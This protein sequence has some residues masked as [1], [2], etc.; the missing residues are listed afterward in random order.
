[1]SL[2][3]AG[4][5]VRAADLTSIFPV[6]VD[7]WQPYIP[8]WTASGSNPSIGNGSINGQYTKIGRTVLFRASITAG[9]TTTFGSGNYSISLPVAGAPGT[10]AYPI[11]E[12]SMVDVSVGT[13]YIRTLIMWTA[14]TTTLILNEAGATVTPTVPVTWADGDL[15][16]FSGQYEAAS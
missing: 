1:M 11:G 12:T 7:A 9:S 10:V 16:Y 4:A 14:A 2:P 3:L 8:V 15:F 13:R 5:P 6:G